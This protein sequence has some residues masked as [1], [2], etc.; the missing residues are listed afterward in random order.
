[1][2]SVSSVP[3]TRCASRT[4]WRSQ[5]TSGGGKA[6]NGFH[7]DYC[8]IPATW[9]DRLVEHQRRRGAARK[10][11]ERSGPSW[12]RCTR[13]HVSD[14]LWT[15]PLTGY[16][17]R[18]TRIAE[19]R[20]IVGASITAGSI[21]EPLQSCAFSA[22]V[23]VVRSQ[24]AAREFDVAGVRA[25]KDGPLLGVVYQAEMSSGTVGERMRMLSAQTLVADSTP[26]GEL[27]AACEM[28]STCSYSSATD[29][30]HCDTRRPEQTAGTHIPLWS[31][32]ATRNASGIL[33]AC[34]VRRV[35]LGSLTS[36]GARGRRARLTERTST[37]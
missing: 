27:L 16:R 7:I 5:H 26:L 19:M 4:P 22:P 25:D 11:S 1:M 9:R 28:W 31:R 8:F 24:L 37:A 14:Q 32:F 18:G 30:R 10:S 23:E 29:R 6:R 21:C 15:S 34:D 12:S 33:G 17:R 35:D 36:S 2:S 13:R 3:T 20:A